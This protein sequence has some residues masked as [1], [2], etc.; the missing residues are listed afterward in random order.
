M[1][2]Q[3]SHEECPSLFL[4]FSLGLSSTSSQLATTQQLVMQLIMGSVH[5]RHSGDNR[6]WKEGDT[7]RETETETERDTQRERDFLFEHLT[8][9]LPNDKRMVGG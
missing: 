9:Y 4:S 2:G 7:E 1:S 3:E 8:V 6:C 5:G